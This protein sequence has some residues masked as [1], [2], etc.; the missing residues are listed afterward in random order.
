MTSVEGNASTVGSVTTPFL[1]RPRVVWIIKLG[2]DKKKLTRHPT[3]YLD[4][5]R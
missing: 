5:V 3:F 1:V 4:T 2:S